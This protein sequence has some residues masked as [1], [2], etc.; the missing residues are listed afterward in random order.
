MKSTT[1]S[2]GHTFEIELERPGNDSKWLTIEATLHF[3]VSPGEPMV[4]YYPDGS[5]YP[6]SPP[7]VELTG[8]TVD[9]IEG[10][11]TA[12]TRSSCPELFEWLER[13]LEKTTDS[14]ELI[15]I[16]DYYGD[17]IER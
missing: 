2:V 3:D 16:F 10:E 9:S 1:H 12:L 7:I 17:R 8:I 13:H 5:G 15:S 6:G 4:R 11:D 14:N